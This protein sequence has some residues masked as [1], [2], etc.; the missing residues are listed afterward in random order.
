[1]SETSRDPL[2]L[3]PVEMQSLQRVSEGGAISDIMYGR[4]GGLGLIRKRFA[5]W[6]V[7]DAGK[8]RLA[9]ELKLRRMEP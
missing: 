9:A 6:I 4:L 2:E 1:M 3:T 8:Y 5:G 7:T